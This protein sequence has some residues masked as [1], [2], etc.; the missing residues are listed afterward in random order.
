ME[1]KQVGRPEDMREAAIRPAAQ[2]L[3]FPPSP[4]LFVVLSSVSQ[5]PSRAV[6]AVVEA[7]GWL[8]VL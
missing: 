5:I 3:E 4:L 7:L 8:L 1:V 6:L 2:F